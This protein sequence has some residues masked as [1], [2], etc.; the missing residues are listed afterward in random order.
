MYR[1][2][3]LRGNANVILS[4]LS[5][6]RERKVKCYNKYFISGHVFHIEEYGRGRKTYNNGVYVKGSTSNEFEVDYYEK[7]KELIELKYYNKYNRVFLFKF[8]WYDTTKRRIIVDSHG[9]VEINS[10]ARLCNVNDV[11]V[12]VKQC[13]QVYYTYTYSF[14]NDHSRVDW[15]SVLKTK[16][17]NCTEVVQ[18]EN[19]ESNMGDDVFQVS[20]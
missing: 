2:Y 19:D 4:L 6:D 8:Y 7:L 11:F 3:K 14:R 9:L 15:L 5:L 17:R 18:D 10:K 13:H 20:E 16:P 1:V 12:F